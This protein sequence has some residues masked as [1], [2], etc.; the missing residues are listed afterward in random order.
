MANN[1]PNDPTPTPAENQPP[2]GAAPPSRQQPAGAAPPARQESAGAAPPARQPAANAAA[3]AQQHAAGVAPPAQAG[4]APPAQPG[5]AGR[6]GRS[7]CLGSWGLLLVAAL[8]AVPLLLVV[9]GVRLA[10]ATGVVDLPVC[11]AADNQ[12]GD[13]EVVGGQA[14]ISV[15]DENGAA[16]V[17][18]QEPASLMPSQFQKF[19]VKS[20]DGSQVLYVTATSLGMTDAKMWVAAANQPKVLLK[21]LGD[22]FWIA[23]PVWCQPQT[24][25]PGRIAYVLRGQASA[26]LTGLEL[27]VMNDD[28]S[29]DRLVLVGTTANG[30]S[31]DLFYGDRP[32]PVRFVAGCDGIKY[33][34]GET[35]DRYVVDIGTGE[36][37]EMAT[38][39][40]QDQSSDGVGTPGIKPG[41]ARTACSLFVRPFAQT[42]PRWGNLRMQ[43]ENS[44]IRS[45]GCALT[46]TAMVFRYYGVDT[47]PARLNACAVDLADPLH[48]DPV[49][50]R[51][52]DSKI[53]TA[54]WNGQT[55]WADLEAAVSQGH[56]AVVGLQ[57]GPAGSH[58]LVVTGGSGDQASNYKIVDSWDGSTYKTLAD[59]I[60]P[61]KGYVLKWLV[62]FEGT[63]PV[64]VPDGGPVASGGGLEPGL[65][66][67]SNPSDGAV[68]NTAQQVRYTLSQAAQAATIESS[69]PD[70][71]TIADEGP[72]TVTVTLRLDGKTTRYRRSFFIDRTPPQVDAAWEDLDET[73]GLL[74]VTAAD[75]LTQVAEAHYQVD[76]GP[77][78]PINAAT[79]EQAALALKPITV[80]GLGPGQHRLRYY[81]VDS[82][83]NRSPERELL[84]GTPLTPTPEPIAGAG[85]NS[86]DGVPGA[87]PG[88]EP[89]TSP[90][91]TAGVSTDPATT[92]ATPTPADIISTPTPTPV[93]PASQLSTSQLVVEPDATSVTFTLQATGRTAVPWSVVMSE[94]PPWLRL[95]PES[96]ELPADGA[97]VT[98]TVTVDRAALGADVP[99]PITLRILSGDT[100][101][102]ELELLVMP[103]GQEP[104]GGGP[105]PRSG[106]DTRR[107]PSSESDT[108][109]GDSPAG[110]TPSSPPETDTGDPSAPLPPPPDTA[111]VPPEIAPEIP[112][113]EPTPTPTPEPEAPTPTPTPTPDPPTPTATPMPTPTPTPLPTPTPTLTPTP[114]ATPEPPPEP[115]NTPTPTPTPT[116]KPDPP[117]KTPTPKP[118]NTP[119]P[120]T[121]PQPA[122]ATPA[123]APKP[124]TA[125]PPTAPQR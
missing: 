20:P 30:F 73:S 35:D 119:T 93:A 25:Q 91:T 27:W 16:V 89:G 114:T 51:C 70:G 108:D 18:A 41:M 60:N 8:I 112:P 45:W 61:K 76:D 33:S 39:P 48:W 74:N 87:E 14:F 115:T 107:A 47:D 17:V 113:E 72:H 94:R 122:T 2:A 34:D 12:S 42:D 79:E 28:G 90:D 105:D 5:D 123:T 54:R 9:G 1:Q 103:S 116:K 50:A 64:C 13:V 29:D 55:T 7:G 95:S 24:G 111:E 77:W 22:S 71:S 46:S 31:P 11:D 110:D 66:T 75:A 96:G 78:Q 23:R 101:V 32:T 81:A 86:G 125:T 6:D 43:P 58:F 21:D 88:A 52:A 38:L 98:V 44:E 63:P 59:Y 15:T 26:D 69:H 53:P 68:Y 109:S 124:A 57:G 67:F 84:V 100:T 56:P 19:V 118:T 121:A 65:L 40:G 120:P 92:A 49:R 80:M 97:P 106:T 82:A 3:P 85:P 117:T 10:C 104:G 37:R 36:V 83:G 4:A 102:A 62:V 99:A